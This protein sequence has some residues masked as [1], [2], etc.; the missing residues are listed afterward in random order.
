MYIEPIHFE[1]DMPIA[2][3]AYKAS[4]YHLHCHEDA[5]EVL[6]LLSGS[7][8]V[9]VSFE[10][11][12]LK[13]GDYIV[14][15]REDSHSIYASDSKC[16]TASLFFNMAGYREQI[17]YLDYVL[18][19]CESFDLAMYKNETQTLRRMIFSVLLHLTAYQG[20]REP[21]LKESLLR[22]AE[23]LLWHLVNEYDMKNYYSRNW[24]AGF[25]KTETYYK[26]I[27]YILENYEMKNLMDYISKNEFYS[28]SY[29]THLFKQ[30]GASSFQ[31]V[32]TYVRLYRSERLL[33]DSDMPIV[34]IADRCG[35]SDI[36]YY[37]NNFKKWFLHKPSEY[38]KIYQP[39]IAK[40]S[41]FQ[42]LRPE[43]V[44]SRMDSLISGNAEDT[45]YKA[46]INPISIKTRD[47]WTGMPLAEQ[48]AAEIVFGCRM[49]DPEFP[50][51]CRRTDPAYPD[52]K[53]DFHRICIPV[54]G[55][56]DLCGLVPRLRSLKEQGYIPLFFIR[57]GKLSYKQYNDLLISLSAA[58]SDEAIP[59]LNAEAVIIYSSSSDKRDVSRLLQNKN[60]YSALRLRAVLAAGKNI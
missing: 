20:A 9:K 38:R 41:L 28:K 11:F 14:I 55:E 22:S 46:A 42:R 3:D 35:F 6:I 15:N 44:I 25:H 51:D 21:D 1:P 53:P 57:Y 29:I 34:E 13:E 31:D 30:V 33:L 60:R 56:S 4:F 36:K 52:E 23:E 54:D 8:R 10:E 5:I 12:D 2:F 32:L 40:R 19:A 26:I 47:P 39:E 59:F 50:A 49:A 37:T 58:V 24:N 18:F 27:K 43:D 7:A 48:E 16:E 17:P 45:R